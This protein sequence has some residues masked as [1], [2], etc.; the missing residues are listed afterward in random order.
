MH[1]VSTRGDKNAR[2]FTDISFTA[3]APRPLHPTAGSG[4]PTKCRK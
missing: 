1:Y 4:C 3:F 2:A